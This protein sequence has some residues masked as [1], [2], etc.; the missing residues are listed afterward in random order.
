MSVTLSQDTELGTTTYGGDFAG[1]DASK[2]YE[3]T[4]VQATEVHANC[5]RPRTAEDPPRGVGMALS[6]PNE[7]A[8]YPYRLGD[9]V[10]E[11]SGLLVVN[12]TDNTGHVKGS[13]N[14]ILKQ[15]ATL[16]G[17]GADMGKSL[18]GK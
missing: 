10:P 16:Y 8:E 7:E 2:T 9:L 4:V 1:L 17:P 5:S 11:S 6:D 15:G 14:K 12:K 18:L 3:L 13:I